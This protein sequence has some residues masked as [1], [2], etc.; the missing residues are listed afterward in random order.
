M[1]AKIL[2]IGRVEK[3]LDRYKLSGWE[4][5]SSGEPA[6]YP[7]GNVFGYSFEELSQISR[8]NLLIVR[9]RDELHW[10]AEQCPNCQGKREYTF[11][12]RGRENIVP[13]VRCEP[14]Y[15]LIEPLEAALE[16]LEEKEA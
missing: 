3:I 13:C 8:E 1:K 5:A 15:K 9:I 10:V 7:E 11:L 16:V 2:K 14:V 4:F 12:S 6:D